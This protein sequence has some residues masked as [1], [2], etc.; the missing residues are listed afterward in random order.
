LES[1]LEKQVSDLEKQLSAGAGSQGKMG[2]GQREAL[3]SKIK[4]LQR[5][6]QQIRISQQALATLSKL[7]AMPQYQEAM[8]LLQQLQNQAGASSSG[9]QPPMSPDE[10][11]AAAEKLEALANK[12]SSNA[13]MKA[14]ADALLAAAK[15]AKAGGG[16]CSGNLL[17]VFGLNAPFGQNCQSDSSQGSGA[18]QNGRGGT[19]QGV[20]LGLHTDLHHFDKSSLLNIKFDNRVIT[21][22]QGNTGPVSYTDV[23]GPAKMTGKSQIPYED[24]LPKY[25]NSAESALSKGNVPPEMRSRVRDYFNSLHQ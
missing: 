6:I 14:Y 1:A 8:K 9:Q 2:A 3:Q 12:L 18:D 23:T 5:Q 20:Y 11:K 4:A 22:Q 15:A 24:V 21:S 7:M 25:E 13:A 17:S 10:L 19:G 16:Q